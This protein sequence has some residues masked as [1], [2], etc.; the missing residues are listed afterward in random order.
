MGLFDRLGFG[1]HTLHYQVGI[2][3]RDGRRC[4][5]LGGLRIPVTSGSS[6][7]TR[8]SRH[9]VLAAPLLSLP[10]SIV[11]PAAPAEL[12]SLP[13]R[14]LQCGLTLRLPAGEKL[15]EHVGGLIPVVQPK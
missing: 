10:S 2:A 11:P 8:R 15:A 5:S 1:G 14:N 12:R 6:P 9:H 13:A 7:F 3:V 4:R